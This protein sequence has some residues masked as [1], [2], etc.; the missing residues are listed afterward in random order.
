MYKYLIGIVLA[1]FLLACEKEKIPVSNPVE[2]TFDLSGFTRIKAGETYHVTVQQGPAFR[3]LAKGRAEDVADLVVAM[4][5]S[6]LLSFRYDAFKPDRSRVD[7]AITLP[8]LSNLHLQDAA[9]GEVNGFGQ[10]NTSV[11]VTLAGTAK[12]RLN[13]L[14]V[15]VNA[16]LYANSELTLAGTSGDLIVSLL[17]NAKLHAYE[18]T[19]DDVDVYAVAKATAKL[20]VRKSLAAFASD[21]S[22]IYYKGTPASVN[23]EEEG[24]GK[25]IRE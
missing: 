15:L 13:A 23:V 11:R 5:G 4:E 22:R 16:F 2:K 18:A 10:Q 25:V 6:N 24:G 3:I 8:S 1:L 17:A 14:P 7:I 21:Q 12:C 19:F 20:K 9:R